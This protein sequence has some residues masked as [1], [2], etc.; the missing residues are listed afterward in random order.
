MLG[1]IS[2]TKVIV[3]RHK[4]KQYITK[5]RNREWV[6]LIE[7][8]L[9]KLSCRRPRLW[10]IFKGKQHQKQWYTAY[11]EA[12][13]ALS[14]K[15]WTDNKLRYKWIAQYYKPQTWPNDESE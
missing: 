2:K 10:F 11:E 13:I 3:S 6:S 14:N 7:C 4:K 12:Y 15:G 1:I 8:I 5:P 9:L